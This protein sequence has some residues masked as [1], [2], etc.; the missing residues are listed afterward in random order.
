MMQEKE[1]LY[2]LW[3]LLNPL[4]NNHIENAVVYDILLLLIYNVKSPIQTTSGFMNEYLENMY[5]EEHIDIESFA[6]YNS[7]S[8]L[9]IKTTTS[10]F[11]SV[12]DPYHNMALAE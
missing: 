4:N 6:N 8:S 12:G 9:G 2:N 10:N 11:N 1:F 7:G 5:K 3:I